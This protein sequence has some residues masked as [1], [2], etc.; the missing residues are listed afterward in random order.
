MSRIYHVQSIETDSLIEL[1]ERTNNTPGLRYI[2]KKNGF[3]VS[4]TDAM[5]IAYKE[6]NYHAA[7]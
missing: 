7:H 5:N 4:E 2:I 1:Y 3:T 6:Y